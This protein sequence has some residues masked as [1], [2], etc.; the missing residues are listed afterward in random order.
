MRLVRK[1]IV[2]CHS[3]KMLRPCC[4]F[5]D[6][7]LLRPHNPGTIDVGHDAPILGIQRLFPPPSP[8]RR[9]RRGS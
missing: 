9:A 3:P 5:I 1:A 8:S 7:L 2:T 6:V 4:A